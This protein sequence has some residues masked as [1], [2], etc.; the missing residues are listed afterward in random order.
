ME[1]RMEKGTYM[2]ID[3]KAYKDRPYE[4]YKIDKRVYRTRA[5]LNA[6]ID[7][8]MNESVYLIRVYENGKM[9]IERRA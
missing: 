9:I 3:N 5:A 4:L 2:L 7:E 8:C 6:L 1:N